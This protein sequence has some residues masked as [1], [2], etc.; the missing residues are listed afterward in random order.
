[1]KEEHLAG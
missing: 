1:M